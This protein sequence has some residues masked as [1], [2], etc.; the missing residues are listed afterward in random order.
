VTLPLAE[1]LDF[2]VDQVQAV[3]ARLVGELDAATAALA[4]PTVQE[5]RAR[6]FDFIPGE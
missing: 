3:G 4:R 6:K 1:A 2:I 5:A